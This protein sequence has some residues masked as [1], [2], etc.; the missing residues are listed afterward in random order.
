LGDAFDGVAFALPNRLDRVRQDAEI[1]GGGDAD[2]GIAVIDAKSRM[3]G[4]AEL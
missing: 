2:A 1:I 3:R 4:V